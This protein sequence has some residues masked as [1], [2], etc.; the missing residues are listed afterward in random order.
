MNE[1]D[2]SG[3]GG[4]TWDWVVRGGGNEKGRTRIEM[5]E[6]GMVVEHGMTGYPYS[7]N[8]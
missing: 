3:Y 4:R 5:A 1:N 6:L 7:L 8:K 2:R